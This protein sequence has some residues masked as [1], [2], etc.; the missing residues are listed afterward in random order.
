MGWK[1]EEP[2]FDS[3]QVQEIFLFP[4]HPDCFWCSTSLLFNGYFGALSP[5][6]KQQRQEADHSPHL[7]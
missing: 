5:R 7:V 3:Q 1:L 2:W 4:Q 6:V